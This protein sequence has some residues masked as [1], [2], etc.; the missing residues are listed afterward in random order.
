M[1]TQRDIDHEDVDETAI[2][3]RHDQPTLHP[4]PAS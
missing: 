2:L 4:Q 1:S 3:L